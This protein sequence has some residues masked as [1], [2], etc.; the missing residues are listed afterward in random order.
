MII[1]KQKKNRRKKWQHTTHRNNECF[2]HFWTWTFCVAWWFLGTKYRKV[3]RKRHGSD[4]LTIESCVCHQVNEENE[5][6]SKIM[7]ISPIVM[8]RHGIFYQYL[9]GAMYILNQRWH[10][11]YDYYHYQRRIEQ[12]GLW[13]ICLRAL[14]NK[15]IVGNRGLRFPHTLDIYIFNIYSCFCIRIQASEILMNDNNQLLKQIAFCRCSNLSSILAPSLLLVHLFH[16]LRLDFA[17]ISTKD[18]DS[19]HY[20]HNHYYPAKMLSNMRILFCWTHSF[21]CVVHGRESLIRAMDSRQWCFFL[22]TILCYRCI[23][24]FTYELYR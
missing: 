20:H 16:C 15:K 4:S 1:I 10:P 11:K 13:D 3:G 5:A 8:E 12:E 14:Q 6:V 22:L 17:P 2:I 24:Y 21:Y 9:H 7:F 23:W 18:I 19:I